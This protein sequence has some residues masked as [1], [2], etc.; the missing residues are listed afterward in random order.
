MF[1]TTASCGTARI[2]TTAAFR[3]PNCSTPRTAAPHISALGNI[4]LPRASD[5]SSYTGDDVSFGP[6]TSVTNRAFLRWAKLR[7][8]L[9]IGMHEVRF[10]GDAVPEPCDTGTAGAGSA[11]AAGT[12][13]EAFVVRQ[14]IIELDQEYSPECSLFILPRLSEPASSPIHGRRVRCTPTQP[15]R[16]I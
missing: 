15:Q 1:G 7:R 12:P 8:K 14:S 9:H 5:S 2:T 3:P 10:I 11:A 13:D 4:T 16:A 6:L